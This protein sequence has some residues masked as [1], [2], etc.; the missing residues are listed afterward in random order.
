MSA[1]DD[2]LVTI[3]DSGGWGPDLPSHPMD[4]ANL[5]FRAGMTAAAAICEELTNKYS[6][7]DCSVGVDAIIKAR[8]A[9]DKTA[10]RL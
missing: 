5:A 1:F 9:I 3:E 7:I 8:D 4:A 2:W 10:V 6:D